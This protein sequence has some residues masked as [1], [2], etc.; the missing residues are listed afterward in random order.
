MFVVTNIRHDKNMSVATKGLSRQAY[1]CPDK[2]HVLSQQTHV[3]NDKTFVMTKMILVA[4]PANDTSLPWPVN[5]LGS[6][7]NTYMPANRIFD[8]PIPDLL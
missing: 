3:C 4:V 6:K 8:S 1:F 2:R 5:F 7:V